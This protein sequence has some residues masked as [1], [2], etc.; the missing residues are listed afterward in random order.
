MVT[1]PDGQGVILLGCYDDFGNISEVIY[2][3]KAMNDILTWEK[4]AQ[5]MSRPKSRSVAMLVPD[6]I[7]DCH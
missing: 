1:S 6:E 2:E 4:M 3:L 7:T 5:K